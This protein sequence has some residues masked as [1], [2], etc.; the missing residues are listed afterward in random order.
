MS[1][2][3]CELSVLAHGIMSVVMFCVV[4]DAGSWNSA[5]ATEL[6]LSAAAVSWFLFIYGQSLSLCFCLSL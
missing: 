4:V 2:L 1:S 3:I 5:A 6:R